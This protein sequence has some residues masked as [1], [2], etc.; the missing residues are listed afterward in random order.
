MPVFARGWLLP[1]AIGVLLP[2]AYAGAPVVTPST[3]SVSP[4]GAASYEVP[5]RVAPGIAGVEPKLSF[6][7][8]SQGGNGIM[9]IGWSLAG[10]SAI[11]R[12][13]QTI[14]Q[15]GVHGTVSFSGSDRFCL[16]GKRLKLLNPTNSPSSARDALPWV[17]KS[18]ET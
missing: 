4:Q 15:D 10:L 9:G 1:C 18:S 2:Q 7:Y 11:M 5:I 14:A 13:P 12:C 17:Q 16:D 3:F 8:N 6:T